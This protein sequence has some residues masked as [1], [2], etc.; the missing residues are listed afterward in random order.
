MSETYFRVRSCSQNKLI[1]FHTTTDS[2]VAAMKTAIGKL[3]NLEPSSFQLFRAAS[4]GSGAI[5]PAGAGSWQPVL[6]PEASK[7]SEL[8]IERCSMLFLA[9]VNDG[10]AESI[11]PEL[12]AGRSV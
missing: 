11:P 1:F 6:L 5:K 9:K 10:V 3:E 12:L 8:P 7:I 2:T 4:Q